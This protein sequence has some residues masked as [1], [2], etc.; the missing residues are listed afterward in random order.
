MKRIR[1]LHLIASKG[2]YGAERVL[3]NLL[4]ALKQAGID[5]TLGCISPI[6]SAGADVGFELRN[7]NLPVVFIDE[8]RKVS[9]RSLRLIWDTIKKTEA[10]I[11]HAHGYKATILG[12]MIT[13]IVGIPL[14][15]TYH[16]EAEKRPEFSKYLAIENIFLRKAERV[17]PVSLRIREELISRRVS[18]EKMSVIYNGI[19][20]PLVKGDNRSSTEQGDHCLPHLACVGRLIATKR[21]DL[22]I[23]AVDML[24]KEYPS[25]FLSIAGEGPYEG[26]L[27]R[28]VED[29]GLKNHVR[30]LGYLKDMRKI[31][32]MAKIFVLLSETEGSPVA[33]IE[34][35]AFSLPIIV[36]SVGAVPEMVENGKHALIIAPNDLASLTK[37]IRYIMSNQKS[38]EAL[39]KAAREKFLANFNSE[40]MAGAYL[41]QYQTVLHK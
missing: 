41:E 12:G 39:G 37:S 14:V 17:F 28:K 22:A 36:T 30:F 32:E 38:S 8:Q 6:Y 4:P 26:I 24:R 18:Q 5:V 1:V 31:Y 23:E 40:T 3:L 10:N 13:R 27:K 11:I 7:Q 9:L 2:L 34:A 15:C 35:M 29:L 16:G 25:I 21:F 33:L 19:K 20:D